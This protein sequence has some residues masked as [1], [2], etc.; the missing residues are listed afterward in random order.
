M[1]VRWAMAGA[2][3]AR[4]PVL[5]PHRLLRVPWVSHVGPKSGPLPRGRHKPEGFREC[6][7]CGGRYWGSLCIDSDARGL[8]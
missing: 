1:R 4:E 3:D 8:A 6:N 2:A 5:T 7:L